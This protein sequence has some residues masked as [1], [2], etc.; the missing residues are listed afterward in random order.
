MDW[1]LIGHYTGFRASEWSQ[2]T[3]WAFDRVEDWPG[4]PAQAMTCTDFAFMDNHECP[5]HDSGL[6][7][8]MI[9]YLMV[10]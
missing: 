2:K 4:K 3:Q 5:L 6:S 10:W 7:E 1:I 9:K 8:S